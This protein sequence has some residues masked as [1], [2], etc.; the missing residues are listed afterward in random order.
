M[1]KDREYKTLGVARFG[2]LWIGLQ[3]SVNEWGSSRHRIAQFLPDLETVIAHGCEEQYHHPS[4]FE[5]QGRIFFAV[6]QYFEEDAEIEPELVYQLLPPPDS[7]MAIESMEQRVNAIMR[8]CTK[9][10]LGIALGLD[11][12]VNIPKRELAERIIRLKDRIE[13]L[14][15]C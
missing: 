7:K 4:F 11:S 1:D 2:D 3:F 8:R 12:V 6:T 15:Q 13:S 9:D 10:D 5:C 14:L